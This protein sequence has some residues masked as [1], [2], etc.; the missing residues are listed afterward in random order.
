MEGLFKRVVNVFTDM[1]NVMP[2]TEWAFC[3]DQRFPEELEIIFAEGDNVCPDS[4]GTEWEQA[5][6][7]DFR[8]WLWELV[9]YLQREVSNAYMEGVEFGKESC[10]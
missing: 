6:G 4:M 7:A 2:E 3:P 8:E 5:D 9:E 10:S 1:G